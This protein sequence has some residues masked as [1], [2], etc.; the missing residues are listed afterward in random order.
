MNHGESFFQGAPGNGN[1]AIGKRLKQIAGSVLKVEY[2][3]CQSNFVAASQTAVILDSDPSQRP[4]LATSVVGPIGVNTRVVCLVYPPRG[5]LVIGVLSL[6]VPGLIT[7]TASGS[8]TKAQAA[9]A[10]ALEVWAL[11]GGGAGGGAVATGVGESSGG[12]GGGSGT[13]AYDL[14]RVSALTFPVTV[15]IGAGGVAAAGLVGGAGGNTTFGSYVGGVGAAGGDAAVTGTAVGP[16]AGPGT[17]GGILSG[18]AN[19]SLY[20]DYGLRGF[21]IAATFFMPGGG[22][23]TPWGGGGRTP[24][25]L[26]SAGNNGSGFGTGGSGACNAASQAARAGGNGA[27]GLVLVKLVY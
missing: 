22:A 2:A 13:A 8:F 18:N 15:T 14:L 9:G 19:A 27:Q 20:G 17:P 3:T 21:R 26:S 1:A 10:R 16:A 25:S 11:G 12:A 7:F 24:A 5:L 6:P 4:V 23:R